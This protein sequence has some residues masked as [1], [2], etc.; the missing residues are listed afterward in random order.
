MSD[1]SRLL[2][3][4]YRS[5][6]AAPAAPA[7]PSWSSDSALDDAFADWVPG[8]SDDAHAAERAFAGTE[9][10]PAEPVDQL[11]QLD[12]LDSLMQQAAS[13]ASGMVEDELEEKP[14]VK[15]AF[16]TAFAIEP[17]I[18]MTDETVVEFHGPVIEFHEPVFDPAPEPVAVAVPTGT[19]CRQDDDILPSRGHG[20]RG[21]I[22]LKRR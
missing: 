13:I 16:E 10:E 21:R 4:V 12:S 19:W 15:S 11:D 17:P 6:P 1:L 20:R 14:A 2:E 5:G 9:I 3:D 18:E 7:A 8:P 22:S